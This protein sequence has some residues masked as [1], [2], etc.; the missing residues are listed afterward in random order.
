MELLGGDP[1]LLAHA[2]GSAL[3]MVWVG[4]RA[5]LWFRRAASPGSV[6]ARRLRCPYRRESA[7]VTLVA[8]A[9][10]GTTGRVA[11]CSLREASGRCSEACL[12]QPR[13]WPRPR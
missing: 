10:T 13:M 5:T 6:S 7:L 12:G 8:A 2:A 11:S 3:V 1:I 4:I 9:R